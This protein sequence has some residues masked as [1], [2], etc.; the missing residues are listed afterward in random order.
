MYEG[1]PGLGTADVHRVTGPRQ[2]GVQDAVYRIPRAHGIGTEEAE[3]HSLV[4]RALE[5]HLR[6]LFGEQP[7]HE[8]HD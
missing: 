1:P 5:A 4:F 2:A 3:P 8:N 7:H 6:D